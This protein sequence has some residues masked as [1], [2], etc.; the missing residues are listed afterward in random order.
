MGLTKRK[1]SYYV[2]FTVLDDGKLLR[3]ATHGM[4]KLKRWKVGSRN[5]GFAKDQEAVIK[6]R[7][8]AG[9]MLS[10]ALERAQAATFREW[11]ETYLSLEEVRILTTYEDRKCGSVS[12]WSSSGTVH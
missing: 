5:R 1:D 12:W 9:Q 2:E 7:L 4:G 10:P 6:T 11:A 3:L 8:L